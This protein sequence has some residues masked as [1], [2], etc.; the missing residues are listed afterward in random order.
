MPELRGKRRGDELV[1]VNVE[2]PRN[3]SSRQKELVEEL[4]KTLQA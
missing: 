2:I 1:K 4:A 3:L